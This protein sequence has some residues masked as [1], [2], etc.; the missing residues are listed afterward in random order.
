MPIS[1]ELIDELLKDC[2]APQDLLGESG[3]LSFRHS[4]T[5]SFC[6]FPDTSE[7]G[8]KIFPG[9]SI[10]IP[11]PISICTD[12]DPDSVSIL[13]ASRQIDEVSRRKLDIDES[14]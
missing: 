13:I 7:N 12:S 8:Q 10:P 5:T 2:H 4:T 14:I 11:I 3:K 1:N 6:G 9:F